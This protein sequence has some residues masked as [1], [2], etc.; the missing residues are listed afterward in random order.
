MKAFFTVLS[1]WLVALDFAQPTYVVAL[2]EA[3]QGRSGEV[4]DRRL[5]SIK[6]I[7]ERQQRM[8]AKGNRD[9]S[10]F[11]RQHGRTRGFRSDRRVIHD[12][13]FLPLG[14]GLWVDVVAFD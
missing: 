5:K 12:V 7:V 9:R 6:T 8:L 10:L 13:A 3:M 14:D 4:R 1:P 11:R 2:K